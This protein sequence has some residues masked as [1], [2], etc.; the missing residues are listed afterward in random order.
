MSR[1]GGSVEAGHVV[2]EVVAVLGVPR[3]VDD[4]LAALVRR[5][6]PVDDVLAERAAGGLHVPVAVAIGVEGSSVVDVDGTAGALHLGFLAIQPGHFV[7]VSL[8]SFWDGHP[9]RRSGS[10]VLCTIL[11]LN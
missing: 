3:V 11:T 8:E 7:L 2:T 5:Q 6:A 9:Q 1:S 4:H 10:P